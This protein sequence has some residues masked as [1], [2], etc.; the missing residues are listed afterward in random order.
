MGNYFDAAARGRFTLSHFNDIGL[1]AHV[2]DEC[3]DSVLSELPSSEENDNDREISFL[4]GDLM[5]VDLSSFRPRKE[6]NPKIWVN[7][8][9]NSRVRMRLLDIADD[10]IETLKVEWAQPVDI[11]LT[12]SLAN[13][14]WSRYSDFDLHIIYDFKDVD[15][16]TEFVKEYFDAK[17]N[18]WNEKHDNLKIYG[19]P[20][21]L[22]VQD[23]N[24]AHA[25]SGIYSLEQNEWVLE[26]ERDNIKAIKLDK[27]YIKEKVAKFATIIDD[28]QRKIAE[29][30]DLHMQLEYSDKVK[31]VFDK[32]KGMRKS[33][34][35]KSGGNEMT[36]GNIIYKCLRRLGY[37]AT[38]LDLKAKTYDRIR[39]IEK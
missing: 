5:N 4:K 13:Y 24:E 3:M 28:L 27:Y 37:I 12:G 1:D 34:L 17:K 36:A 14:N 16:K 7:G 21:E 25:A 11:I 39:S 33:A 15:E 30:K 18:E 31:R 26:P 9:M 20:V 10:F 35:G 22:Y 38:L 2:I 8:L 6:L 23:S 29:E 19:Y 32:L